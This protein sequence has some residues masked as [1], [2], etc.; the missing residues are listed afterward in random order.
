MASFFVDTSALAKRY[1]NEIGTRWVRNWTKTSTGNW[2][3]VSELIV[4]EMFSVFARREYDGHMT[5]STTERFRRMFLMHTRDEYLLVKTG[6]AQLTVAQRLVTTHI[7]LGLRALDAIHLATA[8][9][10]QN[11]LG[12]PLVF[13]SADKKLLAAAAAEGFTTDDPNLHP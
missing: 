5:V 10:A 4:V 6:S 1:T 8:L 13:V 7:G 9:Q 12:M 3:V 2:I 11:R